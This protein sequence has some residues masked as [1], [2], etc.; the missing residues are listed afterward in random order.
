MLKLTRTRALTWPVA[1]DSAAP[2]SGQP[3]LANLPRD[4]RNYAQRPGQAA[5]DRISSSRRLVVAWRIQ[6]Y[7]IRFT[8]PK[9]RSAHSVRL[10]LKELVMFGDGELM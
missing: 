4:I 2:L 9:V 6:S 5:G 7:H 10:L 3:S 8:D 1:G